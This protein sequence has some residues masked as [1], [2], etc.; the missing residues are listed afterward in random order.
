[1]EIFFFICGA[2]VEP[3]PFLLRPFIGLMYQPWMLGGDEC[4]GNSGLNEWQWKQK[5]SEET[6]LSVVL[7]ATDSI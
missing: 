5:F 6:F 2:G 7:S 4:G 1:V 3:S